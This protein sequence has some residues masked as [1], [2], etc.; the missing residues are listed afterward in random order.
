MLKFQQTEKNMKENFEILRKCPLFNGI[1]DN[2]LMSMLGCLDA[3]ERRYKNGDTILAEGDSAKYLGIVLDGNVQIEH[4]DYYGNRSIITNIQPSQIF[5]E[6]FACAGLDLMPVDVVATA[7]TRVL[8]IDASRITKSCCKACAFHSRM[9]FN[10]LNIVANKN[11]VFHQK[12]EIT[13]KRTTR[14]KLMTYLLIQ[15]KNNNSN[16]FTI[17]YDRQELADY[18]EVERSGLSAE[19]SKLKREQILD[20]R[21]SKFVLNRN[22]NFL[23]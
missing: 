3:K 18:L 11:L 19:I 2:D 9:V 21:K 17:P 10:L 7:D 5:G 22:K 15:A 1:E 16:S 6:S 12:I 13:S 20:C 8:M 23:N 4:T 14:E